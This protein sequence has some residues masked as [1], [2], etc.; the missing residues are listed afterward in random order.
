MVIECQDQVIRFSSLGGK[1]STGLEQTGFV[2]RF[3]TRL[4]RRIIQETFKLKN[5]STQ[6]P[7]SERLGQEFWTS[8]W[9]RIIFKFLQ[10]NTNVHQDLNH[11]LTLPNI[12]IIEKLKKK[13]DIGEI[14][15]LR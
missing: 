7:A 10:V 6:I 9:Y 13:K 11:L 4:P 3:L 12:H 8:T 1:A 2:S 15:I 14:D 5:I